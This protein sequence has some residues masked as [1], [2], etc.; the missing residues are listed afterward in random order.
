MEDM[1]RRKKG[2]NENEEIQSQAWA[3]E[4][5]GVC[6]FVFCVL[7]WDGRVS[8]SKM[9]VCA[10]RLVFVYELYARTIAKR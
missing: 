6:V 8:Y 5:W 9:S 7:S 4:R 1:E 2:G 3:R 10:C